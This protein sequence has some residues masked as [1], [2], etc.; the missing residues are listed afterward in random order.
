MKL[1]KYISLAVMTAVIFGSCDKK[2]AVTDPNAQTSA[3]FW[4]TES[5]IAE[6]VVATYNLLLVDG[7][8]ART[9]PALVDVR[10]DDVNSQ[11]PWTIYPLTGNFTVQADYAGG[12]DVESWI[13]RDFYQMIAKANLVF[14]NAP[15]VTF[16]NDDYKNRLLGQAYFLR[17]FAYYELAENYQVCPLVLSK[18]L[19]QS[20]YFP[21]SASEDSIWTAIES[22]LIK[23]QSMLPT[24]YDNVTGEDQGQ[25]GR[26]TWGAATGLLGKVYMIRGDYA[27]AAA[28]FKKII[29]ANIYK[30]VANYGD[31]FT[32]TNENNTE[33]IFEI[34]FGDFGVDA[35]WVEPSLSSWTQG[36]ALDFPYGLTQYGAWGDFHPTQWLYSEFKKERCKDGKLD[37]R[38]YWTLVTYE[39]EYDTDG[40]GRSNTIFGE[41]PYETNKLDASNNNIYIAKYTYARIPG[42]TIEGDGKVP[43]SGINYRFMR[44]SEILLLYAEA[45]NEINGPTSDVYKYIQMVRDRADLPD[46]ATTK[47]GLSKEE[48]RDQIAHERALEF[49][50]EGIRFFDIMRWKWLSNP[51]KLSLLK[52]HD[53]EFNTYVTGHEYLPVPQGELDTNPNLSK[54]SAN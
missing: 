16:S 6:G 25:K 32:M 19:D 53:S 17:A 38:L 46:L 24:S 27:K 47:P 48:M 28:E 54:N 22:D 37:P 15:N 34:Q 13:W 52:S 41:K 40:D 49:G 36:S 33:S 4:K 39:K 11:S 10:G 50:V 51:D 23:A 42:H 21:A 35:N 8:F 1:F 5:D 12:Y 29:D 26:A 14:Y 9:L 18:P 44:Y 2:L 43:G 20:E 30:L 31:N 45:L 7:T 3:D